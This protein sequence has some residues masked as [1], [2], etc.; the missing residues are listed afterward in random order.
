MK[1]LINKIYNNNKSIYNEIFLYTDL[2]LL[3]S[4]INITIV[5]CETSSDYTRIRLIF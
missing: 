2:I 5:F 3:S 1:L 4:S